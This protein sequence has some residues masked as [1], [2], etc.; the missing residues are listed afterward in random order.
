M[1]ASLRQ[2]DLNDARDWRVV[3]DEGGSP[4]SGCLCLTVTI[5]ADAQVGDELFQVWVTTDRDRHLVERTAG[6]AL[7]VDLFDSQT[8]E[9]QLRQRIEIVEAD[10]WL[11]IVD[12]LRPEYLWE[13]EG[14]TE[15]DRD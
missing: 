7:I 4:S 3:V 14:M 11:G 15:R 12:R 5:G 13:Y 1:R 8:I 10:D 2:V 6:R 9:R